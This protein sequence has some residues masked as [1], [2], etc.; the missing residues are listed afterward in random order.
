MEAA[1]AGLVQRF[2]QGA[3]SR[4]DLIQGLSTLALALAAAPVAAQQ[5]SGLKATGIS[6]FGLLCSDVN[7]STAFYVNALGMALLSEDKPKGIARLGAK[8][9]LISLRQAP[10]A[11]TVDHFAIS[12]EGFNE[13]AAKRTLE[14][15]GYA[16][17]RDEESGFHLKDPD[18]ANVQLV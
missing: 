3:I 2:E 6:H 8:G 1:I 10:P 18:G 9:T 16:P 13:D 7:R 4:R 11:G 17:R 12:V 5:P 14:Q 15:R